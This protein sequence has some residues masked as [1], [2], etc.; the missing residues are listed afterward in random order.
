L[1][2]PPM[3]LLLLLAHL[4]VLPKLLLENA[5]GAWPTHVVRHQ[6]VN[7]RPDV[8]AGHNLMMM[9]QQQHQ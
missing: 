5:K 4:C 9:Q 8:L 1:L 7:A 3:L 6:L 2:L